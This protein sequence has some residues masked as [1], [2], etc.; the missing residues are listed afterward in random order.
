[1]DRNYCESYSAI[2]KNMDRC[3]LCWNLTDVPRDMPINQRHSYLEGQGQLC[4]RC[5]YELC[6][7]DVFRQPEDTEQ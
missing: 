2:N 3:V 4:A 5:Y 6:G 1:M 7:A